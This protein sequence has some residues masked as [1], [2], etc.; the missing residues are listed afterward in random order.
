M[1]V[2]FQDLVIRGGGYNTVVL[3]FGI[4]LDFDNV[5]VFGG[6]YCM[7]ARNTG[8]SDGSVTTTVTGSS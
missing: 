1:H 4:N 2:R 8:A 7:R 3:Q 6:T 5:I